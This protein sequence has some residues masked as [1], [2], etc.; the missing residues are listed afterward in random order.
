[1]AELAYAIDSK[2][3]AERRV[4]SIPTGTIGVVAKQA[5]AKDLKSFGLI[6]HAGSIPADPTSRYAP[7]NGRGHGT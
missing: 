2:S 3:F 6:I 5:D 7:Q 1:M 4:G